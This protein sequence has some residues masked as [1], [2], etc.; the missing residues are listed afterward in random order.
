M[1][2]PVTNNSKLMD[3]YRL[4]SCGRKSSVVSVGQDA[5]VETVLIKMVELEGK[6]S[7]FY[8]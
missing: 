6:I 5:L 4:S 7:I 2:S 3:I 8:Q 1:C